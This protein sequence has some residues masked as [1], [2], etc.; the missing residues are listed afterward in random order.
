M[1]LD[2]F[3]SVAAFL[4]ADPDPVPSP[5][6]TAPR[7][8]CI[9]LVTRPTEVVPGLTFVTSFSVIEYGG[10]ADECLTRYRRR[11]IFEAVLLRASFAPIVTNLHAFAV[12]G[13]AALDALNA[14]L[15]NP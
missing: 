14:E 15:A 10:S 8:W 12:A 2:H 4:G 13:T 6:E 1:N 7:L 9:S 11:V 5:V 3:R